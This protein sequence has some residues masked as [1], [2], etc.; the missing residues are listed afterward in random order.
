LTGDPDRFDVVFPD[1]EI[2][3]GTSLDLARDIGDLGIDMPIV[4]TTGYS[5]AQA[6]SQ[7][8]GGE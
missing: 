5:Q 1:V 3:D 2:P 7:E 8:R 4:L 6:M